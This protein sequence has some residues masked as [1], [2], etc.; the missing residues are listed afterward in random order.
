MMNAFTL[1]FG[2]N[3]D[4]FRGMQRLQ[5]ELNHI[6]EQW[7]DRRTGLLDR[8]WGPAVDIYESKDDVIVLAD[9][10]GMKK[11]D[12]EVTVKDQVLIIKGE[13]KAQ[14]LPENVEELREERSFGTFTK[15]FT[16]PS[17]V[18]AANVKALYQNGVLELTLPKREDA[19][20]KQI[21][22]KVQ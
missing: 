20:P 19:K 14:E 7:G 6:F 13:R 21:S 1:G 5:E 22:V 2:G 18:D 4:P 10:P 15:A 8:A 12:I 3:L 17:G 11:E 9:I 16:L